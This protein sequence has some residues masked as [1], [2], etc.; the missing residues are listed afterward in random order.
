MLGSCSKYAHRESESDSGEKGALSLVAS[1]RHHR[2][3]S[4]SRTNMAPTIVSDLH[5]D[6]VVRPSADLGMKTVI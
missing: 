6:V 4:R 1:G 2:I 3:T 5:Q